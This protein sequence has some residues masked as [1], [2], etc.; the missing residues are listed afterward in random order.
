ME[1]YRYYK[2]FIL[3]GSQFYSKTARVLQQGLD[4]VLLE[5]FLQ[6]LDFV[7]FKT[8]GNNLMKNII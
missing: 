4:E 7:L 8:H 3:Q 2:E 5:Y 1:K 6:N